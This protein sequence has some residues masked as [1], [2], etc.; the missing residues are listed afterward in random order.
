MEMDLY[1][2]SQRQG[3]LT[4]SEGLLTVVAGFGAYF[5]IVDYPETAKFMTEDEIA[6]VTYVRAIDQGQYGEADQLTFK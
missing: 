5:A 4:D 2:V 1:S 6:W 3:A